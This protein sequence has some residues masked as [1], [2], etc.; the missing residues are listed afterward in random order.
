MQEVQSMR[1]CVGLRR[2]NSPRAR[3]CEWGVLT[4]LQL[5]G[6][7]CRAEREVYKKPEG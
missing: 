2:L 3:D 1:F 4:T 5:L 6:H 7:V